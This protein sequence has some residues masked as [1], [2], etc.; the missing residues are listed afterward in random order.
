MPVLTGGQALARALANEGIEVVFGIVGTHNAPEMVR[1]AMRLMRGQRPQPTF[2]E[3]PLDVAS[4][5]AEVAELRPFLVQADA[6]LAVGT[7]F[8]SV[9]DFSRG[10]KLPEA[11]V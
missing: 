11:L 3:V 1:S 2:I 6:C 5:R 10:A 8:E 9:T 4:A 7:N